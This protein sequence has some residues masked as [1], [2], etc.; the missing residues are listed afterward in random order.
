M[1]APQL[2]PYS[3]PTKLCKS[4]HATK[5]YRC[6]PLHPTPTSRIAEDWRSTAAGGMETALVLWERCCIHYLLHGAGTWTKISVATIQ[7]LN[8]LQQWFIRLVLQV[9]PGA[10]VAVL[11]WETG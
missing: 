3:G 4:P 1:A 6:P 8:K 11:G 5:Y 9:G 2:P 7:K 10:P